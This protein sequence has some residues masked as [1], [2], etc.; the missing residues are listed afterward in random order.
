MEIPGVNM[1]NIFESL[2]SAPGGLIK[3]GEDLLTGVAGVAGALVGPTVSI[4]VD[5]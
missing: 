1:D 5:M 4:K 3:T 2:T